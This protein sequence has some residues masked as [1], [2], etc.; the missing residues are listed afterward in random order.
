LGTWDKD[1]SYEVAAFTIM[2]T[3]SGISRLLGPR[4][5]TGAVAGHFSGLEARFSGEILRRSAGMKRE[6]QRFSTKNCSAVRND[7]NKSPG[8]HFKKYTI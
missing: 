7:L 5:A 1:S 6:Q 3:V 2:S 4:S 8:L